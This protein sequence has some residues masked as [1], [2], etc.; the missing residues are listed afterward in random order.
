MLKETPSQTAGP[1]VHL[2]CVPSLCGIDGVYLED[3][4]AAMLTGAARGE[5]ITIRGR[6]LDGLDQPL[7]DALVE[8]WQADAAGLHRS[9]NET[10]GAADPHFRG[11][12]RGAT[13]MET[14]EFAFETVKPGRVPFRDGR[15]QAPHV[16]FWIAARGINVALA[17]RMYFPDE[18]AANAED[19]VLARIEHPAHVETLIAA[20]AAPGAST[21]STSDCRARARRSSSTFEGAAW[22][23]P[24]SSRWPSPAACRA[25]RRTPRC[26]S[27]S[28]SRSRARMRRSRPGPPSCTPTSATTT[29]PRRRTPSA[30]PA[31]WR[32]CAA[33]AP[34][35]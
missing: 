33:T 24:A 10:R 31:S 3:A 32:G 23:R 20:K 29:R 21:A 30:S 19:P 15:L 25:R 4:G 35:W 2:G 18:A 34:A 7:R 13:D 27:A 8:I 22:A 14:G 5:R 28:P 12:G 26:R 17:T 11:W 6:V 16:S 9:V 1:Y